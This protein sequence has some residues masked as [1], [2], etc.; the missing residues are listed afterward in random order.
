MGTLKFVLVQIDG[1]A[2]SI[3]PTKTTLTALT[4]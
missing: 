4:N 3:R 2:E 1:P